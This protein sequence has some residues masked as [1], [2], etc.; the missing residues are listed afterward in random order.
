MNGIR[1]LEA[2]TPSRVGGAEVFVANLCE[3]LP[4]LGAEVELF[5][6]AGRPFVEY[7]R[8]RGIEPVTWRTRGKIDPLTV[9]RVRRL[10]KNGPFDLI[11]THLS[12]ASLL[13]ALAARLAR[14]PSVAHIHGLNTATSFRYSTHLIAVSEAVKSHMVA[15]GIAADRVGVVYNGVDMTR[16]APVPIEE[17]KA[18]AGYDADA[19]VLGVFGRLAEEKG[20]RTAVEAMSLLREEHPKTK[21]VLA[22]EGKARAELEESARA[23]GVEEMVDFRGFVDD[24]PALMS[25]CDIVLVPSLREGFGLAAVEAMALERPVVASAVGGL[26]EVIDQRGMGVLV[27]PQDPQ[28]MADAVSDLLDDRASAVAMAR[29]ASEAVRE[30]FDLA[31]QTAVLYERLRVAAGPEP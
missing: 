29:Q 25:A 9:L 14:K 10:I 11:H 19:P 5:C 31:K 30:R 28:A 12:T 18:N 26:R 13:G 22:G 27:A 20:Q 2:I 23:L 6:P 4:K 15:Q 1:I 16:F 3:S 17:A 8:G 7:A 21:L 24:V